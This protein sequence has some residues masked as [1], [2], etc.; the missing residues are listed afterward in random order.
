MANAYNDD[1]H[2]EDE[3]PGTVHA[4]KM[5]DERCPEDRMCPRCITGADPNCAECCAVVTD[6][7]RCD[8]FGYQEDEIECRCHDICVQDVRDICC[9]R[10]TRFFQLPGSDAGFG[11][12]GLRIPDGFPGTVTECRVIC[13]DETLRQSG[14]FACLA[15]D[16]EVG[17]QV[18]IEVPQP[19][20]N[21]P[22]IL[23][24]QFKVTFTCFFN[25]FFRFPSGTGFPDT[26]AGRQ[27]FRDEIKLIDGSC[28]TII[29]EEC[30]IVQPPSSPVPCIKVVLKV[31]DKL[32]KHE[33]LLV[34]ALKPYPDNITIKREFAPP[35]RI[36]PCV[37]GFQC[38]G[39][40]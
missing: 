14:A 19:P 12:R 3:H 15:I 10:I 2:Y 22:L 11:C 26:A 24:F 7:G 30:T 34:S 25:E 8:K 39:A 6:P 36:D 18:I 17:I 32:W 37:N 27:A 16:N 40:G 29:I 31:V 1:L 35:H 28:K 13:A 9:K 4:Q 20:P 5:P 33:N 23:V 21:P 38:P